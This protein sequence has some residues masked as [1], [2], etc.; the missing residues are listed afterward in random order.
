M[1]DTQLEPPKYVLDNPEWNMSEVF[2]DAENKEAVKRLNVLEEWPE[3]LNST[4]DESQ[5]EA[6]SRILTKKVAIVQGPPGTGKTFTSV[7]VCH[8]FLA[9]LDG[10]LLK[11]VGFES[12][13]QQHEGR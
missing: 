9:L 2:P 3:N 8:P 7:Q 11:P 4:M 5:K 13:S 1:V 12:N 6:L 10:T